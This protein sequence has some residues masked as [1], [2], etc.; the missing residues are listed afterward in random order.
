[1]AKV[2]RVKTER[3]QRGRAGFLFKRGATDVPYDELDARQIQAIEND[4]T[5]ISKLVDTENE[6][7]MLSKEE[8]LQE[9][10]SELEK[11]VSTLKHALAEKETKVSKLEGDLA[12]IATA[13]R[14]TSTGGRYKA[15]SK[16]QK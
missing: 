6:E 14:K 2:L 7:A 1:M 3:A 16:K 10:I 5:L 4:P 12:S 13:S 8:K 11:Q 15:K 9:Y